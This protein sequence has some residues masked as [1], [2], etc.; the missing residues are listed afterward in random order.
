[1]NT[2]DFIAKKHVE[3][4]SIAESIKALMTEYGLSLAEAKIAVS[5]HPSWENV[6]SAMRPLHADLDKLE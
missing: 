1:M 6:V 4:A 3:G 5:G 2:A